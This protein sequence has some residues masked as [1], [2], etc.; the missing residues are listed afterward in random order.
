MDFGCKNADAFDKVRLWQ[1]NLSIELIRFFN[2]FCNPKHVFILPSKWETMSM[3]M[4]GRVRAAKYSSVV[5]QV[6]KHA[7]S[8]NL[9][10]F[11]WSNPLNSKL[12]QKTAF[13][14]SRAF[15]PTNYRI[16]N[17]L[18]PLA[19]IFSILRHIMTSKFLLQ[20]TVDMN[21]TKEIPK[22]LQG[23]VHNVLFSV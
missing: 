15:V 20:R 23:V 8:N 5:R 13:L 9:K 7:I 19:M 11:Q 10:Q 4:L 17:L 6:L 2:F 18:L 3:A 16:T 1:K 12:A 22:Y 21:Y 14:L